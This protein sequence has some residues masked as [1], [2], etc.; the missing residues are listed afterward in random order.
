MPTTIV[1]T[2]ALA[3]A[4]H[5]RPPKMYLRDLN[6]LERISAQFNPSQLEE[7]LSVEWARLKPPGLSHE[8]LHYDHTANLKI[9]FDLIFDAM[10]AGDTT[11]MSEARKFLQ[12]VCY[13]QKGAQNVAEGEPA[14]VLFFWP[15]LMSLTCVISGGLSFKH[16]RFNRI[17]QPTYTT[18]SVSIEEIR[19]ARLF[20]ADVR[21]N[22]TQRT[23]TEVFD[24]AFARNGGT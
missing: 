18:V 1:D 20:A 12:S 22:G 4:V 5:Q 21:Q 7:T 8:K 24:D 14:R 2:N 13:A 17:G 16:T 11:P 9:K 19:D 6:T 15:N 3:G 10:E 23:S